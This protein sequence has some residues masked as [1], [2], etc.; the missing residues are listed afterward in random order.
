MLINDVNNL[1]KK[2]KQK[3]EN[4]YWSGLAYANDKLYDMCGKYSQ[5]GNYYQELIDKL[6]TITL[7]YEI[8][9]VIKY[10]EDKI[11]ETYILGS[12]YANDKLYELCGDTGTLR[13]YYQIFINE[14]KKLKENNQ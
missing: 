6:K 13:N 10:F 14:L 7:F 3:T 1:I 2:Y 8:D 9:N 12:S 5:S 11:G 4:N